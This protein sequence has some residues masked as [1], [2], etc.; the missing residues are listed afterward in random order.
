M[1]VQGILI[2]VFL[3]AAFCLGGFLTGHL[4]FNAS[5]KV[6][7]NPKGILWQESLPASLQKA[8]GSGRVV[9]VDFYAEWCG[10]CKKMEKTTYQNA[11]LINLSRNFVCTRVDVDKHEKIAQ[12]YRINGLPTLVFLNHKG[13]EIKRLEGYVDA[14]ELISAMQKVQS[15]GQ[16]SKT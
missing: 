8:K 4:P 1:K 3:I 16:Q 12:K 5:V 7:A 15:K 14:S 9:L 6:S 2:G 10:Y 13:S 11:K